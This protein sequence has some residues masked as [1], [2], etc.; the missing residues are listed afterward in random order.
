MKN[1][2]MG[3]LLVCMLCSIG[4]PAAAQTAK[5][6]TYEG[7]TDDRLTRVV[8]IIITEKPNGYEVS[9][10]IKLVGSGLNDVL[11]QISGTYYPAKSLVKAD[12]GRG[13]G[14]ILV[15]AS[16]LKDQDAFNVQ[17]EKDNRVKEFVA[18][19]VANRPEKAADIAGTW[20]SSVNYRYTLVAAGP[21]EYTWYLGPIEETG[22]IKVSGNELSATW[23]NPRTSGSA[24]GRV[25]E[26]D[27]SGRATRIEW[28]NGAV[29]TR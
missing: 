16:R 5:R 7:R 12:C 26:T 14:Y 3:V 29:F 23:S 6:W 20:N 2:W 8:T 10:D 22:R 24:N 19:R 15:T 1:T 17:L 28:S 25:T 11:C 4:M 18:E 9:G 21:G 13:A 27:A